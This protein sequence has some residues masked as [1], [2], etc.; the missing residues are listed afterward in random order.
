MKIEVIDIDKLKKEAAD[1]IVFKNSYISKADLLDNNKEYQKLYVIIHNQGVI[2][3]KIDI[4]LKKL[5]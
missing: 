4:L 3:S 1:V 5:K 2:N